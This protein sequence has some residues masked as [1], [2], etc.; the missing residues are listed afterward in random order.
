LRLWREL[1]ERSGGDPRT[2]TAQEALEAV[3]SYY[4]TIRGTPE[5][6]AFEEAWYTDRG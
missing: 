2:A 6:E 4:G 1:I 3:P 5:Q